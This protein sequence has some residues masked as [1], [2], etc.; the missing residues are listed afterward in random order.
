M[1]NIYV[2][3]E[4]IYN[5]WFGIGTSAIIVP[6]RINLIETLHPEWHMNKKSVFNK[7]WSRLQLITTTVAKLD[8][9][10]CNPYDL[11]LGDWKEVIWKKCS[12]FG[13][14]KFIKQLKK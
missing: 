3:I 8:S 11:V 13:I 4:T 2:S 14:E 5:E 6:G 10:M 7:K 12:L 9:S 1:K